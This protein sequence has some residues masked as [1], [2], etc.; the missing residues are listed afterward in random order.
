[1]IKHEQPILHIGESIRD[2]NMIYIYIVCV[3]RG[4]KIIESSPKSGERCVCT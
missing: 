2:E 3:E 1:M 4:N